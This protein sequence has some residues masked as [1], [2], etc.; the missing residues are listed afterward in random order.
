MR[1]RVG[2]NPERYLRK[3][4]VTR[5]AQSILAAHF[6]IEASSDKLPRRSDGEE[7]V[8]RSDDCAKTQRAATLLEYGVRE[9]CCVIAGIMRDDMISDNASV[10]TLDVE[11][12]G[13]N[14][15]VDQVIELACKKGLAAGGELLVWRFKP[16]VSIS[17]AAERTHGIGMADL[18]HEPSFASRADEI[19]EVLQWADVFMGY[20]VGFDIEFLEAEFRRADRK[21]D[22][23]SKKAVIDP[24]KIW[25]S[26]EPR[27]LEDAYSRFVGGEF[28]NAHSAGGDVEA[29]VAVYHAMLEA[30]S[31]RDASLDAVARMCNRDTTNWIGPSH[32]LQWNDGQAV[33]EFGKYRGRTVLSVVD[34]DSAYLKWV[35]GKE[36]PKHVHNIIKGA[37]SKLAPDVFHDKI[38]RHF[39]P[40]S[41]Q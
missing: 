8:R 31:I 30:F 20:N 5:V 1:I 35:L 3:K 39:P 18:A 6:I 4:A 36:F 10:L 2:R 29:T 40:P 22:L 17:L 19:L 14:K 15:E 26:T 32:H 13:L 12:T 25:Q 38:A 21:V 24:Y 27:R 28:E 16:T 34:L 33:I 9:C 37:L 41:A 11:T 23:C 7:T